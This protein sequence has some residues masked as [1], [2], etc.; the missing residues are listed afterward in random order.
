LALCW[1]G[2]CNGPLCVTYWIL[3][4]GGLWRRWRLGFAPAA[5]GWN[6]GWSGGGLA[7]QMR[8]GAVDIHEFKGQ[9]K[10]QA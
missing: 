7:V 8:D 6:A 1:L 4:W 2:R 9:L 5:W 10:T 3:Y